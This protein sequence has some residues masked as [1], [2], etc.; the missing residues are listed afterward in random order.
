MGI[1]L[2][3]ASREEGIHSKVGGGLYER[4]E[5]EDILLPMFLKHETPESA[6]LG[7]RGIKVPKRLNA[8]RQSR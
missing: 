6:L 1:V 4:I 5:I 7:A 3:R 2:A 8:Y